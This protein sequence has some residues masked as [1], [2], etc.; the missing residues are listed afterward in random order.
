MRPSWLLSG[1]PTI[2]CL[3]DFGKRQRIPRTK[4]I[5]RRLPPGRAL[6]HSMNEGLV[7]SPSVLVRDGACLREGSPAGRM[8]AEH[9][10]EGG[11]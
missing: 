6:R 9:G 2:R 4:A 7:S 1:E 11:G 5:I 3:L 8:P 10:P